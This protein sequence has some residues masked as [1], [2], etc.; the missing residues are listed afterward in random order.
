LGPTPDQGLLLNIE[1][2]SRSH[3]VR[4]SADSSFLIGSTLSDEGL[5][6]VTGV[7]DRIT[8]LERL[9]TKL[10]LAEVSNKRRC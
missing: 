9:L 3:S 10:V 8:S 6:R 1:S 2:R 5:K 7:E 4:Y